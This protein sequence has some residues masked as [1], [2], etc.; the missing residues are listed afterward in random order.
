MHYAIKALKLV[1]GYLFYT[2][3]RISQPV[4]HL[5]QTKM[6]HKADCK[7]GF[8]MSSLLEFWLGD[9]GLQATEYSGN[10]MVEL[11]TVPS[12]LFC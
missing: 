2:E 12:N 8:F 3:L 6:C 1:Y 5:S 7:S 9:C 4:R 11:K 10:I